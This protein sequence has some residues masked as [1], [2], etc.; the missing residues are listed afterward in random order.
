MCVL[1]PLCTVGQ[2]ALLGVK[3]PQGLVVKVQA[4]TASSGT[5]HAVG[6]TQYAVGSATQQ[7]PS[8]LESA[9]AVGGGGDGVSGLCGAA[10]VCLG[11]LCL[12]DETLA[13]KAVPL[14]VQ[15]RGVVLSQES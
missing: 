11:K 4:L 3:P 14:Y 2:V 7:G 5:Q 10:W 15:V 9:E 1:L 8:Q 12:T 6:S 13:K